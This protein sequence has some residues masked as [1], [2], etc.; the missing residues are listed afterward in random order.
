MQQPKEHLV[1]TL[2]EKV[3]AL[4]VNEVAKV[5]AFADRLRNESNPPERGSSRAISLALDERGPLQFE[6]GELDALLADI[7]ETR[8]LDPRERG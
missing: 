7:E 8:N 4:P 6:S 1:E 3:R 2:I 5:V